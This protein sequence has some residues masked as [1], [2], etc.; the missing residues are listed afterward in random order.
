MSA[1]MSFKL[2]GVLFHLYERSIKVDVIAEPI[3][4]GRTV[5]K[6]DAKVLRRLIKL[7]EER[8][9]EEV[10]SALKKLINV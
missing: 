10:S 7:G 1:R 5:S 6:E 2:G 4:Y 9:A 8:K 3:F